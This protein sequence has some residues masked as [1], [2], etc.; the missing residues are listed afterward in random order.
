M[1]EDQT[2]VVEVTVEGAEHPDQVINALARFRDDFIINVEATAQELRV[3]GEMDY[4]ETV[5]SGSRVSLRRVAYSAAELMT[6]AVS[7]EQT[8]QRAASEAFEESRKLREI[9]HFVADLIGRAE[10]KRSLSDKASG[11]IEAQLS[12]LNRVLHR[13]DDA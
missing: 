9:R 3:V 8:A 5:L 6:M 4:E 11:A 2:P 7:L 12:V 13:L 10:K 1:H